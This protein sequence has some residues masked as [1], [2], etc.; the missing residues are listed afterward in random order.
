M[1]WGGTKPGVWGWRGGHTEQR[2]G[3]W[4]LDEAPGLRA[5]RDR[6]QGGTG[7]G[8]CPKGSPLLCKCPWTRVGRNG[9][10][11]LPPHML[12]ERDVWPDSSFPGTL[13]HT[14][15]R[16]TPASGRWEGQYVGVRGTSA[17]PEGEAGAL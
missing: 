2:E 12:A 6:S 10:Q 5:G 11:Q 7:L 14:P 8:R 9:P 16:R 1:Q 3:T 4:Q 17:V 13:A 15:L